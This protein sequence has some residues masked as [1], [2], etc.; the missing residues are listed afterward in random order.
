MSTVTFLLALTDVANSPF[1][2]VDEINQFVD[3]FPDS[4]AGS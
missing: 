2:L 4:P 1:G 3:A